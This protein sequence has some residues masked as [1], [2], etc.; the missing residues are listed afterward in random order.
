MSYVKKLDGV[1]KK[2]DLTLSHE[3]YINKLLQII[4]DNLDYSFASII[5][6]SDE[7]KRYVIYS[8]N[9]PEDYQKRINETAAPILLNPSGKAIESDSVIV[10]NN[11][12]SCPDLEPL[13][14]IM[15]KHSIRAEIWIPLFRAGKPFGTYVLYDTKV[16]KM[17]KNTLGALEQI[18]IMISLAI[19]NHLHNTQLNQKS[20]ELHQTIDVHKESEKPLLLTHNALKI[21]ED[22]ESSPAFQ[23]INGDEKLRKSSIYTN[24]L[25]EVSLDPLMTINANGKIMD[26]NE[27][28]QNITNMSRD[29]L[30]GSDFPG[31]F[32]EPKQ[33]RDMYK[34]GLAMGHIKNYPLTIRH[35][36]GKTIDLLCNASVYG[37]EEVEVQGIFI[38]ARDITE[39]KKNQTR[40]KKLN[41]ELEQQ[42]N[43]LS[44]ANKELS[45]TNNKLKEL[46]KMK[47]E[48]LATVNHELRTPLTSI[49]GYS[50][51]LIERIAGDINEKQTQYVEGI[52]EKGK[53][54]SHI[55][56]DLLDLSKLESGNM[57]IRLEPV[58]VAPHINEALHNEMPLIMEKQHETIVEIAEGISDIHVDRVRFTQVLLNLINNAVKFTED[59]GKI[60]IKADN[61]GDMVKVSVAD[62][63]I[64]IRSEDMDKLFQR[65]VQI[66]QSVSRRFEGTGLGLTITK[67]MVE[68]MGGSIDVHSEYGTGTTFNIFLPQAKAMNPVIDMPDPATSYDGMPSCVLHP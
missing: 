55:V 60:I 49:I 58:S 38:A 63:G 33:A 47:S 6:L 19:T 12:Y 3:Q 66:E 46:D 13:Y 40:I 34:Q 9:L 14:D 43:E 18:G 11:P 24:S 25:F 53:H 54:L 8:H 39:H 1:I 50:G 10:V 37:N 56:N 44:A 30:I 59:N 61:H 68:L 35:T 64:G 32:T 2:I 7:K 23:R 4:S 15:Q 65:F 57:K 5:E 31:Y 51:L 26:A 48:F 62:N 27:A 52:L 41:A 22:S 17:S 20:E 36:L 29:E 21:T 67:N 16:C 45:D 42:T 28:A